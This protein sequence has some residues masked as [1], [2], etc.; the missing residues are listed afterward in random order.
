M[1]HSD[2]TA[3]LKLHSVETSDGEQSG[4]DRDTI[5]PITPQETIILR[6]K[7]LHN[8]ASMETTISVHSI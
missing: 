1:K 5:H 7:K 4:C 6:G 8:V 3:S 2:P